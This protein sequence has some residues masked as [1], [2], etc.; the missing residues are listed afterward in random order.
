MGYS[1]EDLQEMKKSI[2]K[3]I[4]REDSFDRKYCCYWKR[5]GCKVKRYNRR[6]LRRK[7]EGIQEVEI[8]QLMDD[9]L[10]ENEEALSEL[11]KQ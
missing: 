10:I 7:L 11:A 5:G 8:N 9:I 1:Y 4:T 2:H 3:I 6:L